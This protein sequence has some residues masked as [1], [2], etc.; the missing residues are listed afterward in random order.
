MRK[1][2]HQALLGLNDW[3]RYLIVFLLAALGY[4]LGQVPF[5]LVIWRV[6]ESDQSIGEEE[7]NQFLSNPDFTLFNLSSNVGFL[8]ILFTFICAMVV[9]YFSFK[10]IH[11]R[12]FLTLITPLTQLRW[13]RIIFGFGLWLTLTALLELYFYL[14]AP[15]HYTFQFELKDFIWLMVISIFLLPIQTSFEEIFFRGYLMQGIASA[16]STPV[17]PLILTTLGFALI[18]GSNPEVTKFGLGIMMT[19]YILAGLFLGIITLWDDGL[20]LALGVHFGTN[21]FGA[22]ILGYSGAA[23]QTDSLLKTS[24]LNPQHM[25]VGFIIC[26]LVFLVIAAYTFGWKQFNYLFHTISDD[27]KRLKSETEIDYSKFL[28]ENE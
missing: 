28:V 1:F 8:L 11:K 26:A 13:S 3:Y 18:H 22:V 15:E 2:L 25:V 5:L 9:F 21:F 17:I 23:I 19:Y 24:E 16:V 4:F 27:R 7:F 6:M 12:S 10:L 14:Q 20:E